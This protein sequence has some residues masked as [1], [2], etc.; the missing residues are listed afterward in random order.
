MS[1]PKIRVPLFVILA[2]VVQVVYWLTNRQFL[3]V[4]AIWLAVMF[5]IVW[6]TQSDE[7]PIDEAAEKAAK[8]AKEAAQQLKQGFHP[9]KKE[10]AIEQEPA[11]IAGFKTILVD[12]VHTFIS[13]EWVVNKDLFTLLETLPNHKIIV[14]NATQEEMEQYWLVDMPY[15]IFSLHH[16]PNKNDPIYFVTLLESFNLEAENVVYF[17]HDLE[18]VLSAKSLGITVYHYDKDKGDISMIETFLK[19]HA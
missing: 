19:M 18:A 10:S 2:Y 12:A 7:Q 6:L 15:D 3:F 8:K 17:D 4:L 13:P 16:K 11:I 1:S 9:L 14:T 5:V